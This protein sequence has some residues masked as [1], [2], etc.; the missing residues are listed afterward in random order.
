MSVAAKAIDEAMIIQGARLKSIVPSERWL[1]GKKALVAGIGAIGLMAA[2]A[3]SLRG[4]KVIGVDIVDEQTLRPRLLKEIGGTYVD[5]RKVRTTDLDDTVGESNFVFEATGIANLQIDLIDALAVNGIYVA[6]GIPEGTRPVNVMA[7]DVMKQFVLK[8]QILLG[9]VNAS[10]EHYIMAAKDL[11][12]SMERWPGVIERVITNRV[13]YQNFLHAFHE[14]S[15]DDIKEVI[16]W[17]EP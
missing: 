14:D 2:F 4:A 8:N 13:S 5:G 6:T 11:E 12:A 15:G 9:S 7:G 17:S 1:D 16:G 3:L 10:Y